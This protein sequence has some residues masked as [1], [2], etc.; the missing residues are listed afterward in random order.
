M[1][2]VAVSPEGV[3]GVDGKIP[4][5]HP[6]DLK[7]FKRLTI[8]HTVIMGRKTWESMGSK[9]LAGR[10]NIVISRTPQAGIDTFRDLASA[11]ATVE[12]DAWIIGGASL[13][14]EGMRFA[15]EID[16][17]YVPDRIDAPNAV[18][19]P[20]IDP[21]SFESGEMIPHEDAPGLFRR[22]YVRRA[23]SGC[24]T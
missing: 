9:P 1:M 23:T 3:I 19:F 20:S 8:G 16:V 21:L 13:Y 2:I 22:V 11:M 4:W 18:C 12:G 10:R 5:R 15:D 14:E 24:A 17:T 6:G 7:R